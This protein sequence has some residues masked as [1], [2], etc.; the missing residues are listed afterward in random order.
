[1]LLIGSLG[2]GLSVA[3]GMAYAGKHFD[4]VR[5]TVSEPCHFCAPPA[6]AKNIDPAP[7][8]LFKKTNKGCRYLRVEPIFFF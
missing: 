1:V 5:T 6:P 3:C 8:L 7:L 2:Q 4:K